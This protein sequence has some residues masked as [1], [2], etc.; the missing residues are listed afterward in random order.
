[1]TVDLKYYAPDFLITIEGKELRHGMSDL[2]G[3]AA[4]IDVLSLTVTESSD[5]ADTFEFKIRGRLDQ[6]GKFPRGKDLIWIDDD[7]FSEGNEVEIE[8]GYVHNRTLGFVG[9]I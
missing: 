5:Q 3:R 9:E 7:R 2:P 4:N 8:M 1:M 6:L